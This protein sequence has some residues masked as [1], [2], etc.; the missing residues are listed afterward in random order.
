MGGGEETGNL[1]LD[2]HSVWPPKLLGNAHERT[3]DTDSGPI[4]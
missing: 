4:S 3:L 1:L 2:F